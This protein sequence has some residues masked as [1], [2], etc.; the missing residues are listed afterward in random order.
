MGYPFSLLE[1]SAD[2]SLD[3]VVIRI[4]RTINQFFLPVSFHTG[5]SLFLPLWAVGFLFL[6]ISGITECVEG[7]VAITNIISPVGLLALG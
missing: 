3:T 6:H 2:L 4:A 7:L 5:G 1:L